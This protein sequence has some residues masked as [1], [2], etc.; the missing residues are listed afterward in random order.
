MLAPAHNVN[1]S[2]STIANVD[3][4][5]FS[6]FFVFI[7][8]SFVALVVGLGMVVFDFLYWLFS[9]TLQTSF[10]ASVEMT[11]NLV[12]VVILSA[13]KNLSPFRLCLLL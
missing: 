1:A 12:Y 7:F 9:L 6:E 4:I 2:E 8:A 13:T 10:R 3:S 11:V 5:S